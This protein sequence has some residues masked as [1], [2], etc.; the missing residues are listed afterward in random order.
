M[1]AGMDKSSVQ[2][3]LVHLDSTC[4]NRCSLFRISFATSFSVILAHSFEVYWKKLRV[5]SIKELGEWIHDEL[6]RLFFV[7]VYK[8]LCSLYILGVSRSF[9]CVALG[10]ISLESIQPQLKVSKLGSWRE[11]SFLRRRS[12]EARKTGTKLRL[13]DPIMESSP[14]VWLGMILNVF[15]SL[16]KAAF[17]NSDE[18]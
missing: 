1:T 10:A 3:C 16:A 12:Q 11:R 9:F 18:E 6:S 7:S 13:I 2:I 5:S 17:L 8:I 15:E 14:S 4:Q